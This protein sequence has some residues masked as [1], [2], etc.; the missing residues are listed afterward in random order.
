MIGMMIQADVNILDTKIG[1]N[2]REEDESK[3]VFKKIM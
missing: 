1:T 2:Y 3:R